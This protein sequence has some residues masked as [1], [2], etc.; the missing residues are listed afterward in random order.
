M[1]V[2][3]FLNISATWHFDL[4]SVSLKLFMPSLGRLI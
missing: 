3:T 2:S 4:E 1:I